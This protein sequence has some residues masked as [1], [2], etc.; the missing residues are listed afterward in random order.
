VGDPL[1][2]LARALGDAED[3][4]TAAAAL[5]TRIAATVG[6]ARGQVPGRQREELHGR[7][8][9][10]GR[11][12]G[13]L[14]HLESIQLSAH[15]GQ[16]LRVLE[17]NLVLAHAPPLVEHLLHVVGLGLGLGTRERVEEA[18]R[19]RSGWTRA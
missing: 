14:E 11:G 16:L 12:R 6:A 1:L 2:A 7:E 4:E 10:R 19:T 3:F 9:R 18:L 13:H 5:C 8:W 15:L 17:H